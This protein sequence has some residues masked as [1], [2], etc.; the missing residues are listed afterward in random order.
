MA[1]QISG[2]SVEKLI[3]L[4][5][6]VFAG[7]RSFLSESGVVG[8]KDRMSLTRSQ[9]GEEVFAGSAGLDS[10][11]EVYDGEMEA[12]ALAAGRVE[13]LTKDNEAVRHLHFF[14][15]NTAAIATICDPKPRAGQAH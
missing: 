1:P 2:G 11:A 10:A 14:A 3:E 12:L 9:E 8:R 15:D 4:R 13:R 6:G 7:F 5:V